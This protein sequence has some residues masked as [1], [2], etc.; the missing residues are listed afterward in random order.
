MPPSSGWARSRSWSRRFAF[1]GGG[2]SDGIERPRSI[3]P[4]KSV[5]RRPPADDPLA[6]GRCAPDAWSADGSLINLIDVRVD[7]EERRAP[8]SDGR[9]DEGEPRARSLN[10]RTRLADGCILEG[11]GR[12]PLA[13]GC[14]HEAEG[15]VPLA[16]G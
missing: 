12:A 6:R 7:E 9:I 4:A 10:G 2:S 1:F 13:D 15:R 8:L 14:I 3:R 11:E 5:W 16:E